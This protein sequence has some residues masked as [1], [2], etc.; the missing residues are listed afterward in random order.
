MKTLK[1]EINLIGRF[2][3]LKSTEHVREHS[4]RA[5]RRNNQN[6]N[7]KICQCKCSSHR[8]CQRVFF[9]WGEHQQCR[10]QK[11]LAHFYNKSR[12]LKA[13]AQCLS[14]AARQLPSVVKL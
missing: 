5:K 7:D 13:E 9:H 10:I 12:T 14:F 3:A 1:Y 11:S 2:R 4:E 8:L 6:C